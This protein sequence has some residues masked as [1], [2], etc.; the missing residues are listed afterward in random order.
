MKL[1][2]WKRSI[3]NKYSQLL[4]IIIVL[5][6]VAPNFEGKTGQI[7]IAAVFLGIIIAIIRTFNLKPGFFFLLLILAGGAF[8]LDLYS[9]IQPNSEQN[10]LL[11]LLVQIIYSLF[12]IAALV[13]INRKI[14]FVKKV[15][16]DTIKGGISVF[17]LIGT[18]W[19]L[20][21][22]IVATLDPQ[23]FSQSLDSIDL[24]DSMF[25]FS[26]T[27]LTTLGYGDITPVSDLARTLANLEAIVGM[28]YPAI[29]IARLVGLYTA[30]E[31]I[32]DD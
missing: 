18:V 30:Q 10:K 26:F 5:F 31:M 9:K 16:G 22:S 25:Y 8:G 12:V 15:N 28:M 32:K 23:A 29:F 19:A 3:Q 14:F 27:T 13:T 1:A 20:F 17:F 2:W 6:I 24:L 4:S 21:Y 11:V 7:M